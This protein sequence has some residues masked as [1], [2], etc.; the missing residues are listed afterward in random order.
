MQNCWQFENCISPSHAK[1]KLKKILE[2]ELKLDLKIQKA[3]L[4]KI[5]VC[6]QIVIMAL[7]RLWY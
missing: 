2:N 5:F 3:R 4:C 6:S 1:V 7:K